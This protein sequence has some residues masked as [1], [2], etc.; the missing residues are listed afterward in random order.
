MKEVCGFKGK[1]GMFYDKKSDCMEADLYFDIRATAATL[2]SI[3]EEVSRLIQND[4][5][6][7]SSFGGSEYTLSGVQYR[8]LKDLSN[9]ILRHS[10]GIIAIVTKKKELE[11]T[12][13]RLQAKKGSFTWWLEKKWW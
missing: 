10:E 5:A 1:N 7:Y 8:I 4:Y 11:D 2:N 3:G 9:T 6:D 12:L 13:T